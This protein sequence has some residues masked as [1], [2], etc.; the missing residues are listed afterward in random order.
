MGAV[1]I[2]VDDARFVSPF[3]DLF[4]SPVVPSLFAYTFPETFS[5]FV[6]Q[7]WSWRGCQQLIWNTSGRRIK[8]LS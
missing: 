8:E 3:V 4:S 5:L 7:P 2:F 1:Y 6:W